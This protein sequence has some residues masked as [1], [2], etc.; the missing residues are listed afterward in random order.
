MTETMWNES[1]SVLKVLEQPYAATTRVPERYIDSGSIHEEMGDTKK[2]PERQMSRRQHTA[3]GGEA[4]RLRRA[5]GCSFRHRTVPDPSEGRAA[6][7][8]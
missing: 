5:V 7:L 4:L 3:V 6:E 1:K 8:G 2:S